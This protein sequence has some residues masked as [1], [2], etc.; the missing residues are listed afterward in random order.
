MAY[1]GDKDT[2]YIITPKANSVE[3][4]S[5]MYVCL[6][7]NSEEKHRVLETNISLFQHLV[8]ETATHHTSQSHA[9]TRLSHNLWL[10]AR[11]IMFY[12]HFVS[13]GYYYGHFV[14]TPKTSSVS[15]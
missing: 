15:D 7:P 3:H 6:Y 4:N 14:F 10:M 9:I 2:Y 5:A 11:H 8:C 12:I 1:Y 13:V